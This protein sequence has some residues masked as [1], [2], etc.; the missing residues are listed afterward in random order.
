MVKFV[1]ILCYALEISSKNW[2]WNAEMWGSFG[3]DCKVCKDV[4]QQI[5][6]YEADMYMY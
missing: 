1:S 4:G 6:Q 5:Y 3:L 2:I